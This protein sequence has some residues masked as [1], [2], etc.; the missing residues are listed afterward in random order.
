MAKR[1]RLKLSVQL[2]VVFSESRWGSSSIN[3]LAIFFIVSMPELIFEYVRSFRRVPRDNRVCCS[4]Y[5]IGIDSCKYCSV[6]VFKMD[7]HYLMYPGVR[8]YVCL[9]III[10]RKVFFFTSYANNC[11]NIPC[12]LVSPTPRLPDIRSRRA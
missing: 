10:F 2:N 4:F 3:F 11:K 1:N 7:V 8:I 12:F 5:A 6:Y 9:C